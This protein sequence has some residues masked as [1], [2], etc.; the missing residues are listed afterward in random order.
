VTSFGVFK[1][2]AL[3]SIVQF[4]SI[5]ILYSV[6]KVL[7]VKSSVCLCE[8]SFSNVRKIIALSFHLILF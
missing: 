7:P 4:V 2:M 3:Y 6:M 5:L 8:V 1:Y